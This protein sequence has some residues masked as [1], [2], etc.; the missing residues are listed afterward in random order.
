M[1]KS[2]FQQISLNSAQHVWISIKEEWADT[3]DPHYRAPLSWVTKNKLL[4]THLLKLLTN[5]VEFYPAIQKETSKP[6]NA[7]SLGLMQGG[8]QKTKNGNAPAH[9][10]V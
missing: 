3:F 4:Y 5:L 1:R 6:E 9:P 7:H 10:L 2:T 8:I